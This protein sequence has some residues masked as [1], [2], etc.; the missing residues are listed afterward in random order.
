MFVT[1]TP[2]RLFS[3]AIAGQFLFGLVLGLP[4]SLFGLPLWTSVLGFDVAAQAR[5]L[6]T[7][8]AGQFVFTAAAGSL[9]DRAGAQRV[10]AL[11]SLL[12][13]TG[14]ALLAA[15][16]YASA[17]HLPAALLAAG[18]ASINAASNTL[19]SAIYGDRRGAMLSLMATFG[20]SGS[21]SA[22]LLFNGNL[23]QAAVATRLWALTLFALVVAILP[24]LVRAVIT[25][26][27][28]QSLLAGMRLLRERPF[29]GLIGLLSLEFGLEAVLAGWTAAFAIAVFSGTSGGLMVGLYWTGLCLGRVVAPLLLSRMPKLVLVL[30]ASALA[31]FGILGMATAAAPLSLAI[32]SFVAGCAVGP[33]APTIVSV[34]GDRYPRQMGAA[35]GLL[36]SIAQL[37]GILAPWLTG[38]VT[39]AYDYRPGLIVPA[40][41]AFG[42]TAGTAMAWRTRATRVAIAEAQAR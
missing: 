5:L 35:I 25:G 21:L 26:S 4:G 11:G 19:V 36:L 24:L 39:I 8:F 37:G 16:S 23:D 14:L 28:G 31:A 30:T 12:I 29:Q 9:V 15:A 1:A 33:L 18:G 40:L 13:A 20:A 32:G 10:L 17:S 34:A 42:I 41:L 2:A 27:S 22:P 7:F 38:R 3:L 6:M